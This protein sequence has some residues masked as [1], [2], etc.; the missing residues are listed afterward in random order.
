MLYKQIAVYVYQLDD[1][2]NHTIECEKERR[3]ALYFIY[4]Y[5]ESRE[6]HDHLQQVQLHEQLQRML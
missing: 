4:A 5:V 6:L 2:F 3:T 1:F